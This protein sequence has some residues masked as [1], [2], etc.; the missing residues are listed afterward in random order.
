[1]KT[2][3]YYAMSFLLLYCGLLP[4]LTQ[5]SFDEEE[6]RQRIKRQSRRRPGTA[7]ASERGRQPGSYFRKPGMNRYRPRHLFGG[8]TGAARTLLFG[9]LASFASGVGAP[10]VSSFASAWVLAS[11]RAASNRITGQRGGYV[12]PTISGLVGGVVV[13]GKINAFGTDLLNACTYLH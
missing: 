1:M 5:A 13:G 8:I 9:G 11:S 2:K 10:I 12:L 4:S 7:T 6:Q 3:Q